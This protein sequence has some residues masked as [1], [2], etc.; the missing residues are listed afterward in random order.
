MRLASKNGI[1]TA[2]ASGMGRAGAL[3]FA[4]EA[5]QVAVVDAL[6]RL[7][8][9]FGPQHLVRGIAQISAVIE[10]PGVVAQRSAFARII[11]GEPD[12]SVSERVRRF[13]DV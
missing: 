2:A 8:P 7:A 11:L 13:V 4:R 1:V 5:A 6:D 12:G 9:I 10:R 3:R